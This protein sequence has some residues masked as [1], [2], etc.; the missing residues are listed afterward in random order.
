MYANSSKVAYEKGVDHDLC[1][2][3]L[4]E[5]SVFKA[6]T[7]SEI[8]RCQDLDKYTD[9]VH[10]LQENI[11]AIESNIREYRRIYAEITKPVGAT[12][13]PVSRSNLKLIF[14]S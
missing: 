7:A 12:G 9:Y 1:K 5:I 13:L 3:L 11:T 6:E 10:G 2:P 14:F 4:K 8:H